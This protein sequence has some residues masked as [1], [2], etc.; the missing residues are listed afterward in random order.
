MQADNL[1]YLALLT[2]AGFICPEALAGAIAGALFFSLLPNER[3][4]KELIV[5]TI[6]SVFLGHSFG[7]AFEAEWRMFG[8][9]MGGA[10]GIVLLLAMVKSIQSEGWADFLAKVMEI[11]RGL[12][13]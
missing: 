7:L 10:L 9:F 6:L 2:M 12:R 4:K 8:G 1:F 5:Y 13:K 3:N 11:Y